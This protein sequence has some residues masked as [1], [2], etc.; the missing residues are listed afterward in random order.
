MPGAIDE[1]VNLGDGWS[2]EALEKERDKILFIIENKRESYKNA[3]NYLRIAGFFASENKKLYRK[4]FEFTKAAKSAD[5]ILKSI[6]H[7]GYAVNSIR[8]MDA[9]GRRGKESL[10]YEF[11]KSTLRVGGSAE[12]SALF[13]ESIIKRMKEKEISFTRYPS[14]FSDEVT[15]AIET[16]DLAITT[17]L[18]NYDI[19][20][21]DF[22]SQ[23]SSDEKELSAKF[24]QDASFFEK[25]STKYFNEASKNH[26]ELEEIYKSSMDFSV[27]DEKERKIIS[28]IERFLLQSKTN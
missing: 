18:E 4:R 10:G 6:S 8:L 7:R 26:F 1:I 27:N 23:L 14:V 5:V 13:M 16:D 11:S 9:F 12:N 3:Y 25:N 21:D 22:A 24:K 20:A 17:N 15:A 19:C 2:S 28:H